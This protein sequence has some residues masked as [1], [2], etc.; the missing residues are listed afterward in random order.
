M[1]TRQRRGGALTCLLTLLVLVLT[2]TRPATD[3]GVFAGAPTTGSY[4]YDSAT[5][6]STG[7]QGASIAAAAIGRASTSS[8]GVAG[9]VV[10]SAAA[11]GFAAEGETGLVE[12]ANGALRDPLTGRFAP[13]PD[14]VAPEP[15]SGLH[16]NS[17]L[18]DAP[19]SLYRLEDLNANYLTRFHE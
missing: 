15:S 14:R 5:Q 3:P 11:S 18:S 17:R 4:G 8:D 12:G 16:G 2:L 6:L 9:A 19:T 1:P 13:N 7:T 10:P